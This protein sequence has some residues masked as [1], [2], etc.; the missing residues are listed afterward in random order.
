LKLL[1]ASRLKLGRE[2]AAKE[3]LSYEGR[4]RPV[5]EGEATRFGTLMH[6]GT[7]V[8]WKT[9]GDLDAALAAIDATLDAD[10]DLF[11]FH[12][13]KVLMRGYDKRWKRDLEDYEVIAVEVE[14]RAPLINP[15]TM[16]PSRTWR[17][18]GKIDAILRRR[19][20]HAIVVREFKTTS[21]EIVTDGEQY[22]LKLSMDSQISFYVIGAESL[23]WP[24][25]ETMYDVIKKPGMRPLEATPEDKRKY[26]KSGELYAKQRLVPETPEE[27]AARIEA[28]I[29][30]NPE[31]YY[32][33]RVIHRME[34]QIEDALFD[35]W[36]AAQTMTASHRAPRAVRN[37]ESCFKWGRQ[38]EFWTVCSMGVDPATLS[39]LHQLTNAHRELSEGDTPNESETDSSTAT[40]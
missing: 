16:R 36:Q 24:P 15:E 23:G 9:G 7:E 21:D 11:E 3:R 13:A 32:R 29:E 38:C 1:T 2:C 10:T 4:W 5:H 8:W 34:S 27:Y 20:D 22:W 19:S 33:R 37:S 14:F 28:D 25:E 12:K 39:T 35:F 6:T 26:T 30:E 18:G 17:I 31:R 40:A